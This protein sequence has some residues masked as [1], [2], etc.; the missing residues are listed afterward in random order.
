MEFVNE[1]SG[2]LEL[3]RRDCLRL[4]GQH[5]G[6]VGRLAFVDHDE[7]LIFP[8]NY[9]M[10]GE[11]V[12]FRTAEGTKLDAAIDGA[13]MAFEIDRFDITA[14]TGWSVVVRGRA[15]LITS[16]HE[17]FALRAT[18]LRSFT[19]SSKD[20][21]VLIDTEVVTGRRVPDHGMFSA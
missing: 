1:R 14:R 19:E 5:Q 20:G 6:D 3:S 7:P 9:A 8:V 2:T 18:P 4:L 21:W 17:L 15:R 10:A 13:R 12:V 11:M 16:P